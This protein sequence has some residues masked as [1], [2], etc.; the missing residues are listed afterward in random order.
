MDDSFFNQA[1][2]CGRTLGLYPGI[3]TLDSWEYPRQRSHKVQD[4][5]LCL[6]QTGVSVEFSPHLHDPGW[7]LS[8]L[9]LGGL[10]E[11][12]ILSA[13]WYPAL[14]VDLRLSTSL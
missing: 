8:L 12:A 4:L 13:I 3:I 2:W 11:G 6:G 9:L 7:F 10:K 5:G 1:H 14:F